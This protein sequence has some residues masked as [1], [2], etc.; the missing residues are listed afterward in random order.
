MCTLAGARYGEAWSYWARAD[1]MARRLGPHYRHV[2]T[3]FSTAVMN[4]HAVTLNVELRRSGDALRTANGFDASEI[5]SLARRSRHLIEVTR[6]I[7]NVVIWRARTRCCLP[8]SV[9]RRKPSA[10]MATPATC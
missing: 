8:P 6:A 9:P 10:S 2:P 4:A 1:E 7:I 5:S 3:S